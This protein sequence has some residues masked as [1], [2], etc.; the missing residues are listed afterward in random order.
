M[1]DLLPK[2]SQIEGVDYDEI[3]SPVVHYESVCL[4]LAL[5]ALEDWCTVALDVRNA[6]LY[7]D[8]N[9]E[10]YMEQPKGF[11]IKGKECK[12]MCLLKALYGL[13]EAANLWWKVL[14]QSMKELGC[15][16]LKSNTGV[17]IY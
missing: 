11:M 8:L 9:E 5:A 12:V 7:S 3:F 13:K 15:Y 6:F 1:P 17:F 14:V 10:I 4:M 16:R 2:V